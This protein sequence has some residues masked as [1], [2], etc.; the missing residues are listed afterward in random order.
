[1][2][3][4]QEKL[5]TP[6]LHSQLIRHQDDGASVV[7]CLRTGNESYLITAKTLQKYRKLEKSHKGY[8]L[9]TAE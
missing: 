2:H 3:I 4:G 5:D 6:A 1:M 9:C 7:P 8:T